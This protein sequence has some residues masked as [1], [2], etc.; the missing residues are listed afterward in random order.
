MDFRIRT[1]DFTSAGRE[2]V[3]TREVAAEML[4]VGRDAANAIH[5]PDL[6][7][8]QNHIEIRATPAGLA[9]VSAVGTLG[10]ALDGRSTMQASVDPARGGEIGLGSYRLAFSQ[11]ADD[12]GAPKVVITVRQLA[13][14]DG[15]GKDRLRQFSLAA[16]LPGKRTM[17]W[18]GIIAALMLF[19]AVPIMSGL[20]RPT[21]EPDPD[22]PD[23][24]LM[25]ASW[26][27]GSLSA[28]H[29]GLEDNCE[30]CH[31]KPFEAV[32]DA[33]C[34]TC[35]E[36]IPD[37][38][39]QQR[40]TLGRPAATGTDAVLWNVAHA[41]GKPGPGA[42]TDCHTEHEGEGRMAAPQ[43]QFC[44]DCHGTLDTRLSDTTL[45]DA[46]DFGTLHPEF[47]VSVRPA[48]G[49]EQSSRVSLATAPR[50]HSGLKF[51]HDMHLSPRGGV[52]Q[53]ARRL[54][55]R[56]G[57]GGQL[58]CNDC[59][60]PTA[61]GVRF[62]PVDMER[63]CETCHSLVY[64]Q[65]G[66][67]FRTLSHGDIDQAEADLAALDRIGRAPVVTGRRRPGQFGEGQIYY[68]NFGSVSP[69][70]LRAR[71]LDTKGLCGDCHLRNPGQGPLGVVPVSQPDRY[72][73]HGWFDH[74]AHEQEDCATC[75]AADTSD[76][77]SD[78]LLPNLASC[79]DCHMGEGDRSA[80][81]PSTCAMCHSYHPPAQGGSAGPRRVG[82]RQDQADTRN[83]RR[84]ATGGGTTR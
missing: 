38:A 61:D 3:R 11:E 50:D 24:V 45:G 84:A 8:E 25:D 39:E 49:A 36:D 52:T 42:C 53:M 28:A 83:R 32:R 5:L 57:Y 9:D 78:L 51:P 80:E 2:I 13:D 1:I 71:A 40:M 56:A 72:M 44:A 64:D 7:V 66:S 46:R 21:A 15:E 27:T 67:T 31:V 19:L 74:Q 76:Q 17:A 41:F 47:A 62:Q 6:A 37:H 10:F 18:A 75:H 79:R 48:P 60:R 69:S 23:A 4:G 55:T 33:T 82:G 63:D 59:H 54:G 35:H 34:L 14:D 26:S 22:Q 77:S 81:V 43:Q 20:S 65:V 73:S 30:S 58:E 70:M 12:A 29:H 16:A 68:N